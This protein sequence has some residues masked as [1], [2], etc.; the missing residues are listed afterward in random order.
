MAMLI[1]DIHGEVRSLIRFINSNE[2][3]CIQLGDFGLIFDNTEDEKYVLDYLEDLLSQ[4]DKYIFTILGNHEN[5]DF[6]DK[7]PESFFMGTKV[8]K[9]T[10]HIMAVCRG[11]I[12]TLDGKSFLC[13]GGADSH[14]KEWRM[15]YEKINQKKIWWEQ[16]I[17]SEEDIQ[18]AYDNLE[19]TSGKVDFILSHTPPACFCY[20]L[21][22]D[23]VFS[24]SELLLE[25]LLNVAEFD[26]WYCG[27][28]HTSACKSIGESAIVSLNIDEMLTI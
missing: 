20:Q 13:L 3:Y 27:H 18:N 1:G 7:L 23:G 12:L 24:K 10:N 9:Y 6:Y 14:D 28:V 4:K 11:E 16:E 5:Y 19:W 26:T 15:E 22:K 2:K 21:Y 17:I 25:Q 8:K